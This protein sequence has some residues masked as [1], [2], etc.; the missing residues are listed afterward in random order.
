HGFGRSSTG[1]TNWYISTL[2]GPVN[3]HVVAGN[4]IV[5]TTGTSAYAFGLSSVGGSQWFVSA[6]PSAP[7]GGIGT[8]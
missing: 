8:R 4:R 3:N 6:L 7:L 5:L 1:G 2:S